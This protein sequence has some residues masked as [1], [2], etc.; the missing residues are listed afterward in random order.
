MEREIPLSVTTG[1]PP[2][3]ATIQPDFL[4]VQ[5]ASA[6]NTIIRQLGMNALRAVVSIYHLL[7]HFLTI[8]GIR[9]E[10]SDLA[11]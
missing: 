7:A 8:N 1:Q 10:R 6:Y 4:I 11:R 9:K 3:Q 2:R 5:V